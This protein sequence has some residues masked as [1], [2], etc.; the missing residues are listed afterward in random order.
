LSRSNP[1]FVRRLFELEVSEI[2]DHT[3]EI[4]GIAREP[5][6]RSKIAVQSKDEK[7]DPVGAC[8]GMR[9]IRVKNIVRELSGEKIDIVRWNEDIKSFVTNALAPAKL[10]RMTLDE[11]ARTVTVIVD[12]TS[13]RWR[14]AR[15]ART[16]A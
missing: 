15:R 2:N 13:F 16:P 3:V 11:H 14:L 12:P 5:G 8:V 1:D 7:V 6:F 4:R 10:T 9:G